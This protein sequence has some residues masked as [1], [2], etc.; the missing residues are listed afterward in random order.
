[1]DAAST[2]EA[3]IPELALHIDTAYGAGTL[4]ADTCEAFARN[5]VDAGLADSLLHFFHV[6][7]T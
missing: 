4:D 1:M 7:E 2:T 6:V 3:Q 5:M